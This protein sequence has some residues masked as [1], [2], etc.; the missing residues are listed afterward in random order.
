MRD[1]NRLDNSYEEIK[2]LH[3]MLSPD[4]RIGQFLLNCIESQSK[5]L[6]YMEDREFIQK[7]RDYVK[8]VRK[9]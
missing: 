1:S 9:I 6:Y 5:D 2:E 3:R 4:L 7:L 8:E